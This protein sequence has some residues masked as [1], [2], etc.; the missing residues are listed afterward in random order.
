[1]P[2]L[3]RKLVILA[4]VDGLVVKP[5]AQRNQRGTNSLRISYASHEITSQDSS[6]KEDG[7]IPSIDAH[8]IVGIRSVKS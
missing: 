8:G 1:M 2:G 4:A 6:F 7:T 5:V 3:V